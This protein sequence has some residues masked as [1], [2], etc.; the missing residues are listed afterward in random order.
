MII[1]KHIDFFV[2]EMER[3]NFSNATIKNYQSCLALFFSKIQYKE[4]P[5]HIN[6]N[7]IRE[8][9]STFVGV[10]Y[11]RATHSAIKKYFEICHNQKHKFRFIPYAKKEKRLPIII[12]NSDIQKLI[13]VCKNKKHK[14]IILTLYGTGVRISELLNIKLSDID[15]K[16]GLIK[17][18]GKG[19]KERNVCMNDVLYKFLQDYWRDYRTKIWLFENDDTHSQYTSRS[20]QEFLT[21]YKNLA[22]IS[23]PVTPHKFRH[24]SATSLLEQGTDLRIIQQLLGHSSSKVTEIY[25]HVSKTIISNINSPINSLTLS[26]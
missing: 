17:V 5:L 11:Q 25:T 22:N 8:Y 6:E 24:S 16:R 20:V 9:L 1:P 14:A 7:D 26:R 21:K 2:K 12:D 4:H 23:S 3:R 19:N 10:N 18:L 15:G 13:D